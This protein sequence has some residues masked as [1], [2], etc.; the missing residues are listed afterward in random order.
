MLLYMYNTLMMFI[1]LNFL[2]LIRFMKDLSSIGLNIEHD[3]Y[4]I[5][6]IDELLFIWRIGNLYGRYIGNVR[7]LNFFYEALG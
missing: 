7:R 2:L 4:L 5:I 1:K 3:L 6:L